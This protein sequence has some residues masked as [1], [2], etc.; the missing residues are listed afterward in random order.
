MNINADM[1]KRFAFGLLILVVLT[2]C[3]VPNP[4]LPA[5]ITTAVRQESSPTPTDTPTA[6]IPTETP[7]PSETPT[8]SATLPPQSIDCG[9]ADCPEN[10]NPLT[11][12]QP[13]DLLNLERRPMAIKIQIYPRGQR[14][15]WGI[16]LADLV[17]EYY[18]NNGMTR[19]NAIYYGN[20][21]E[22]VGP[23]RS[24]RLLDT[25]LVPMYKAVFALGGAYQ[26]ILNELLYSDYWDR[27]VLEGSN[28]C[29]VMCRIEP[30]SNNYLVAN[31]KE[32]NPYVAEKNGV[33]ISRQNLDGMTFQLN[34]PEGGSPANQL[35][36]RYSISAYTRWDYDPTTG[37]YLRFQDTQEA[38]SQSEEVY[39]PFVER[40]TNQ[41]VSADNVLVLFV[42][43]SL[44]FGT[45]FGANEIIDIQLNGSGE[46]VLFRDGQAYVVNWNRPTRDSVLFLTKPMDGSHFA[47]KPGSTWFQV[48]G[49]RSIQPETPPTDGVWRF[50]L[51]F[52]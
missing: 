20:D 32:L 8:P 22:L 30:E 13:D 41:Q 26:L 28:L 44:A 5:T 12:I 24:A 31:T 48:M 47:F 25:H 10:I 1:T 35:S 7:L 6:I 46:A 39:T 15:V 42:P 3:N 21:A 45:R 19:L 23:V 43:H 16:A 18:H 14:P 38:N 27:L 40:D 51:R 50:E 17:Y 33:D 52:P 9:P 34:P 37:R 4:T 49:E 36:V 29:P 2:A 11:G